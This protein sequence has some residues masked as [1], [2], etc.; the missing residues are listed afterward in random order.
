VRVLFTVLDAL[1][2]RHVSA[3][4]TPVLYDLASRGG[5]ARDGALAVMTSAT[6]PNHATFATGAAP[7]QHGI[8]SN[9]IP[10]SG[11]VVPAWKRGPGVPTLFDACATA[12]RTSAAVFGDQHLVGVMG[13]AKANSHWPPSGKP[14]DDARL[15]AMGYIDDRDTVEQLV[16]VLDAGADLVVTQINGPDT[17]AH[18]FGP[19]SDDAFAGYRDTDALLAEVRDHIVWDDTVWVLVSDHDQE[20]VDPDAPVDLQGEIR[21]R[22]LDLFALPE[23]N[24]SLVCGVG[25]LDARQWLAEIDGVAGTEPFVLTDGA[26]ECCLAWTERGRAFGYEGAPTR[27]GTHGGPRTRAQVAAVTGGHAAVE[28]LAR[29]VEVGPVHAADWAPTIAALLGL[30]LPA[31]TGRSLLS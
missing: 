2:A 31:A 14:P 10:E 20:T 6:Y 21:T 5:L 17:A 12:R 19:D 3:E 30:D 18:L 23:G 4:H 11:G 16:D 8:V 26:L 28:P 7:Q 24:A 1:P 15:D 25:A 29:A 9:W 27:A 13:A 22:G